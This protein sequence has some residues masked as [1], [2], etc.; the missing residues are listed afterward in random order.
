MTKL[1]HIIKCNLN[2][3]QRNYFG[4]N[5]TR[6]SLINKYNKKNKLI[7][8]CV[9]SSYPKS[10]RTWLRSILGKYFELAYGVNF[11][12]YFEENKNLPKILFIHDNFLARNLN[13]K[14]AI[15]LI[16]DPRDVIVS[17]YHHLTKREDFY[18]K[19]ISKFIR[20]RRYGIKK[21]I[22][23][24]ENFKEIKELKDE[25]LFIKY[26][27]LRENTFS[28][29]KKLLVFLEVKVEKSLL[30]KAIE[31]MEFSKMQK[32]EASGSFNDEKLLTKNPN[33]KNSFKVRKGKVGGYKEELNKDDIEFLDNYVSNFSSFY[34]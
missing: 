33:E 27:D 29:M 28:E 6:I 31:E 30:E 20:D 9:I 2:N 5:I 14:K 18:Y 24:M 11:S 4:K 1:K 26:E 32:K 23:F 22:D 12:L 19:S 8:D 13:Y 7:L 25:F 17:Y 21:T 15:F 3:L 34:N 16:R 10:G